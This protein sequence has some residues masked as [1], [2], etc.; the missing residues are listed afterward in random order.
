LGVFAEL[1]VGDP[2][3]LRKTGLAPRNLMPLISRKKLKSPM[4]TFSSGLLFGLPSV[5]GG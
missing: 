1:L 3:P 4:P 5:E 2:L